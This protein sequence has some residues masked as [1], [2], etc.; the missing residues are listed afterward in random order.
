MPV[1]YIYIC[2]N[3]SGKPRS[4]QKSFNVHAQPENVYF[5]FWVEL[6][7]HGLTVSGPIEKSNSVCGKSFWDTSF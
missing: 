2:I 6:I 7:T 5:H 1:Q 4:S 3:F